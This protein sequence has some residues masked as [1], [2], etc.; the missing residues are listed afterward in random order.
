MYDHNDSLSLSGGDNALIEDSTRMIVIPNRGAGRYQDETQA[1]IKK[2]F[3]KRVS[4]P[5]TSPIP[6]RLL[7]TFVI[8]SSD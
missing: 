5:G 8:H 6:A 4:N 1:Q 3:Q 2:F 7:R